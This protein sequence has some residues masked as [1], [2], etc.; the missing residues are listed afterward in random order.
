[1][2]LGISKIG[3]EICR[4]ISVALPKYKEMINLISVAVLEFLWATKHVLWI[5]LVNY[6]ERKVNMHSIYWGRSGE[7]KSCLQ[8]SLDQ[9]L[10]SYTR[11]A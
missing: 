6:F 1:M 11:P 4:G 7:I 10:S 3:V 5:R 9:H 2:Q 8:F